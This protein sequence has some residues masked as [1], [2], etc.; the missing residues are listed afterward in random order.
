MM[1]EMFS[2]VI[3][4]LKLTS[5]Y[6]FVYQMEFDGPRWTKLYTILSQLMEGCG[7]GGKGTGG[8]GGVGGFRGDGHYGV[9]V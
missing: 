4:G 1:W 9:G 2:I 6:I 7:V 8:G 5:G 3:L